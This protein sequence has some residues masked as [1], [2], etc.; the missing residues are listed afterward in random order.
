MIRLKRINYLLIFTAILLASCFREDEVVVPQKPGNLETVV[1]EMLPDYTIQTWFS[2]EHGIVSSCNRDSWDLAI[3][4]RE[5]DY[6]LWLNTSLFMYAAHSGI[7]EFSVPL[8]TAG[9]EWK[10]DASDGSEA[11]NAIGKWWTADTSGFRGNGE[12]LLIDRGIDSEGFSRGFLK[13]QPHIDPLSGEV[14]IRI[15]RPDGTNERVFDFPRDPVRRFST[16]SFDNGAPD[17]QTEPTAGRWDL[18]FTTYTTLLFTNTGEPYPYLVNGVLL[19]DTLVMAALDTL[20]P[21][22]EIDRDYAETVW[23]SSSRDMIGYEWKQING[24]VTS[25]DITYTAQSGWTYLVRNR[26]GLFFKMRF[27]DFYNNQ[28]KKGYPTFEFQRL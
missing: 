17:P 23:L 7:T 14:S 15:A 12:V 26:E 13:I 19:N 21:F 2:F 4:T 18:L 6:T 5:G 8:Q 20:K 22:T 28:G 24:D 1:I 27:I 3:A 9:M 11:G 16:L 25:G 10:F